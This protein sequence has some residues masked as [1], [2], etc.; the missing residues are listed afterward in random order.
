MRHGTGVAIGCVWLGCLSVWLHAAT[1]ETVTGTVA[2]RNKSSRDLVPATYWLDDHEF[3]YQLKKRRDVGGVELFDLNFPS[4]VV[5]P[6]PANNTVVAEY[7]RPQGPG[8]YPGIIVLDILGGDQTLGRV[9]AS[10]FAQNQIA[11]LFVQMA[12]YG[13]RRPPGSRLRLV[14]PD[15]DHSLAAVRQTVLDVRR[16]A[17]WLADRPEVDPERLGIIGTSLGSFMGSLTA[18]MEPRLRRV[19]IV[20]GGGGLVDAFYDHPKATPVRMLYE[21]FG[22]SKER[23]QTELAIVDPLTRAANLRDRRVIMI[24]ASRDEVIPPAATKRLWQA[25]GEP[26]IVWYDATH[27]GAAAYLM[28]ALQQVIAHFKAP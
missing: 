18:E 11:A 20:L 9:Q 8:P 28:P 21:C 15:L 6:Y 23:L 1:S 7:Y 5:T 2:F 17:A 3:S 27:T 26:K 13:P 12:Y 14:S 4:P 16:A 19:A 22:G 10:L 25:L 24:G